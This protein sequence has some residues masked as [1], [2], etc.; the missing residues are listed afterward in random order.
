M[1]QWQPGDTEP[2]G[3]YRHP[4]TNRYRPD[5][6]PASEFNPSHGPPRGYRHP[7]SAEGGWTREEETD[8]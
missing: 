7:W 6:T 3:W 5:T 8:P 4:S 2:R 1:M